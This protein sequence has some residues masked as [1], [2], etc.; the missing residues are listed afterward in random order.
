MFI[1]T[2][3][4]NE[5]FVHPL[6]H[7]PFVIIIVR[8]IGTK[9]DLCSSVLLSVVTKSIGTFFPNFYDVLCIPRDAGNN[10]NKINWRTIK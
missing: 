5:M 1:K 4:L 8:Y 6:V 2:A 10:I 3:L 7:N 9:I